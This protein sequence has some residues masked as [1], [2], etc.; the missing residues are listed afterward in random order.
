MEGPLK[1][2]FAT[3]ESAIAYVTL[4]RDRATDPRIKNNASQT[5]KT[6]QH[7]SRKCGTASA[8]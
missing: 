3:V 5:I 1:D 7:L 6:L 2:R 8:C 4:L